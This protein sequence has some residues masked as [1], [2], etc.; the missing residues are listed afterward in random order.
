MNMRKWLMMS[1]IVVLVMLALAMGLTQAQEPGPPERASSAPSAVE[2]TAIVSG[3]IPV[4]GRLTDK[5]GNLL[6]NADY[7]FAFRLYD[8]EDTL[9][10][11]DHQLVGVVDGLFNTYISS[12]EDKLYGQTAYLRVEV[13]ED[14][15]MLGRQY[16][17]PV[18]Y[19][20][21]LR[22]GAL[23]SDTRDTILTVR[24]TG[25]GDSDALIAYAGGDGEAVQAHAIDGAGLFATSENYIALQAYSV[26]TQDHPGVFGCSANSYS[27]CDP[28]RDD[29]AAGVLGYSRYDWG[30]MGVGGN[31]T[32]DGGVYG[33]TASTNGVGGMFY[34]SAGG[35][36]LQARSDGVADNDNIVRF[37]SSDTA[38]V[39]KV[40]GDGD[41]YAD[42]S[43]TG[44]GAD[45]AE[46]LPAQDGLAPGDVLVIG[47]DG[48]L[49]QSAEAYQTSVVGVYSTKPGFVGGSDEEMENPGKVPLAIVGVVPCKASAENGA[50][51][52]GDLLIS[53]ATPGHAMR[54]D[55]RSACIGA[56]IG[57]ALE[58]LETGTGTIQVLVTLQ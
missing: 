41:T 32:D 37:K 4:Q 50:I 46:M 2:E 29:N 27:E 20:L 24:S 47:P 3:G 8:S 31:D 9:L 55:D 28:Y 54:C 11:T 16:I 35:E 48:D 30:V 57:K 23:I 43:F 17:R 52:P 56:I 1:G 26:E 15:Q 42:G 44:G 22:P 49:T 53:S 36:A 5:D 19:A 7:D 34:H 39:F 58:Q 14:G 12:C 40:Q 6:P 51:V 25:S 38:V 33:K 13:E 45:F 10:C 18:P 21:T